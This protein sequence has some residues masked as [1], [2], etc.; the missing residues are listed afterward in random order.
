MCWSLVNPRTRDLVLD[1]P[2]W[3]H[4]WDGGTA[5]PAGLAGEL[6]AGVA[7]TDLDGVVAAT[8]EVALLAPLAESVD[9]AMYWDGPD[10]DLPETIGRTYARLINRQ[11]QREDDEVERLSRLMEKD[12]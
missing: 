4:V 12:D 2:C 9:A 8:A 7:L 6:A 3:L 10:A 11:Q 1:G 5:D